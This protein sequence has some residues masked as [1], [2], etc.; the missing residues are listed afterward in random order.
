MEKEVE[1]FTILAENVF[2][3]SV[4]NL[5]PERAGAF[6]DIIEVLV[7]EVQIFVARLAEIRNV[8]GLV[9]LFHVHS[10]GGHRVDDFRQDDP[11]ATTPCS[12]KQS[13]TSE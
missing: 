4:H 11:I 5:R 12:I 9:H 1:S 2:R 7:A 13:K 3:A 10:I 6:Y 8:D